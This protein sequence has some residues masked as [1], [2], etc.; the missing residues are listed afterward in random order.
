M[1]R[2]LD[3]KLDEIDSTT[4]LLNRRHFELQ[5]PSR[6]RLI[7]VG[8]KNCSHLLVLHKYLREQA[9]QELVALAM[10]TYWGEYCFDLYETIYAAT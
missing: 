2:L 10:E 1:F 7:V 4:S 6:C 8:S 5:L 3:S 9:P